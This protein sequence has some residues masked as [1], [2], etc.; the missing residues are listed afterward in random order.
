M[1]RYEIWIREIKRN[2]EQMKT[3]EAVQVD[4]R[5]E[6]LNWRSVRAIL[7]KQPL[8]GGEEVTVIGEGG[9]GSYVHGPVYVKIV[10]ELDE[11][12]HVIKDMIDYRERKNL[13]NKDYE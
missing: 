12:E 8:E 1:A 10:E 7:S 4:I 6:N 3:G 11:D 5:D 9:T 2:S 13:S